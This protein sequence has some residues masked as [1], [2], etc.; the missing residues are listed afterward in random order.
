MPQ[1]GPR[2]RV[3]VRRHVVEMAL[4][5]RSVTRKEFAQLI[6]VHPSHPP[7]V[8]S[9]RHPRR[10]KVRRLLQ[11]AL[12]KTFAGVFEIEEAGVQPRNG[13]FSLGEFEP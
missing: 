5:E 1:H 12:R 3:G 8:L 13:R 2:I 6:G 10:L 9:G 4:L 7:A 11:A